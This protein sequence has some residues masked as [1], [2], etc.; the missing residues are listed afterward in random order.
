MPHFKCLKTFF[1][2]EVN[3]QEVKLTVGK[4]KYFL[5]KYDGLD[6][7]IRTVDFDSAK[8]A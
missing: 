6:Y 1:L 2:C 4:I 8:L 5:D 3:M 7:L